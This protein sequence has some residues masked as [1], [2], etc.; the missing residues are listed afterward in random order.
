MTTA[1][2][3]FRSDLRM[4]DNPAFTQACE[5]VESLL[6]IFIHQDSLALETQWSFPRVTKNRHVFLQESLQDLGE[7]LRLRGSD[8]F[9]VRGNPLEIFQDLEK[10]SFAKF[11]EALL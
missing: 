9:E 5:N 10:D 6:P 3:W 2:Y 11:Y 7:Q 4:R 1:I 8:L